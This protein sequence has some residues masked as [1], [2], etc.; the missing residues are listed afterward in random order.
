MAPLQK[1]I[2]RIKAGDKC[3]PKGSN[4]KKHGKWL[5][6]K[7]SLEH[8]DRIEGIVIER[9]NYDAAS[10]KPVGAQSKRRYR[11]QLNRPLFRPSLDNES[12]KILYTV[13]YHTHESNFNKI[14]NLPVTNSAYC[15][16][17]KRRYDEKFKKLPGEFR[18][19]DCYATDSK[20]WHGNDQSV[21][22]FCAPS[23]REMQQN[24][25][26]E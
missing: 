1:F 9:N 7:T 15:D 17:C 5:A 18:C 10:I 23:G 8:G 19:T 11:E 25:T 6:E 24:T 4:G 13:R 3:I 14:V 26:K 22:I 16:V 12:L 20:K 21:K 2:D